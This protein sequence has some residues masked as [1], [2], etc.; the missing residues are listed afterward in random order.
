MAHNDDSKKRSSKSEGGLGSWFS[1]LFSGEESGRSKKSKS[2]HDS[3]G[4]MSRS[5]AGRLGGLAPHRCRGR[6]CDEES[7]RG[8]SHREGSGHH[9]SRGGNRNEH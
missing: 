9:S 3:E 2:S 7:E 5:E 6:E 8:Q 4:T 1:N